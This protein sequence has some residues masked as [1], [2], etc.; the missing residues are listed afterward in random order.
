[1]RNFIS[2]TPKTVKWSLGILAAFV[3][4][5]VM[6]WVLLSDEALNPDAKLVLEAEPRIAPEQNAFYALWGFKASP[7]LDA[8]EVGKQIVS[9][10]AAALRS[11]GFTATFAPNAYWGTKPLQDNSMPLRYCK[12][13][14]EKQS[15]LTALGENRKVIETKLREQDLYVQRYRALRRYTQ[16]EDAMAPTHNM[17][18]LPWQTVTKVGELVDAKI[19][20]AMTEPPKRAAALAELD[21]EIVLWKTISRDASTILSRLMATAQLG[22]KYRLASE[23][24]TEYPQI[25]NE[26]RDIVAKITQ[27]LTLE[28]INMQRMFEGE[29]RYTALAVHSVRYDANINSAGA[30]ELSVRPAW[31]A[32]PWEA[33][34]YKRNATINMQHRDMTASGNFYSQ[35]AGEILTQ[36][37]EFSEKLNHYKPFRPSTWLYNPAGKILT[38]I[39]TPQYRGYAYRIHDL[40]GYSRLVELQRQAA[41]KGAPTAKAG[42]LIAA[43][44]INL[45]N[46]YS[47][48][49]MD[50][51][52]AAGTI[53]FAAKG[54]S[55]ADQESLSVKLAT[56]PAGNS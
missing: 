52:A 50:F 6:S 11:G 54:S 44:D 38:S 5:I 33:V 22:R 20:F 29:F 28:D 36:Q 4:G 45:L 40:A 42:E 3:S 31:L 48:K 35:S 25:A 46:P 37:S 23:L 51:D 26:H 27:P 19:V 2:K 49:P 10:Q 47:G 56:Q 41:L 30:A 43:A 9:A 21:A 12:G 55:S 39:V 1:M 32:A 15:C 16:Y 7:E 13:M 53:S 34:T 24:L 14:S 18:V 8:F 17:P